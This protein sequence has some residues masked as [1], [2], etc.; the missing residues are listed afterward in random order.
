MCLAGLTTEMLTRRDGLAGG[1]DVAAGLSLSQAGVDDGDN[2]CC[3]DADG[4]CLAELGAGGGVEEGADLGA[5]GCG[6]SRWGLGV[7]TFCGGERP[8]VAAMVA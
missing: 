8:G 6:W 2:K 3:F 5:G 1:G 7:L 4:V